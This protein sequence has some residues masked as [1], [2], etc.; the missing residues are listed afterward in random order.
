MD[1]LNLNNSD[2]DNNQENNCSTNNDNLQNGNCP[3]NDDCSMGNDSTNNDYS[4][5]KDYSTD[6]NYSKSSNDNSDSLKSSSFYTES[7]R[8]PNPK[9]HNSLFM[10]VIVALVSSILGGAVVGVFFQFVTPLIQPTVKGYFGKLLPASNSTASGAT[11]D[12]AAYKQVEIVQNSNTPVTAI[13]AKVGPSIVGIRVTP[14]QQSQDFGLF[15]FG[16]NAQP[17]EGSGIIIKSDGSVMT[18]YHV[19][20]GALDKNGVFAKGAKIEVF[21]SSQQDKPY[22]ATIVGDDWK[23]DLAVIKINATNLPAAE[24]G[25]SDAVKVGELAVAIGNPGGLE[26]MG[27]VTVGIISGLNRTVPVGDGKELKLLQTDA[28][29]NPGN[30][31]GALVNSAGQVIGV[32]TAKISETG[33]EGLGFAIPINKAKDIISSLM[34]FKYVK[35]RPFLGVEADTRFDANMAKQYSVPAGVLV[36]DVTPLSGAQKA[37]IQA[38]D[39]ITKFD[40]KAVA[41]LDDLNNLKNNHKPGDAVSVE[42]Y[43]D[44]QTKTVQVTLTEDKGST[45]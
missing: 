35:G 3:S 12:S 30:S 26:Y 32:N 17:A 39:I 27:S 2:A 19:I 28:A 4:M 16:T 33:F 8:K 5:G 44:G 29:I 37:G 22:E 11:Q 14:P 41:T 15:N 20:E 23:T 40:G 24:L 34:E 31:G 21:L 13:A 42:F 1:D 38:G 36:A 25:D 45:N 10:L 9:K 7:Y 18:N 43:R 6:D